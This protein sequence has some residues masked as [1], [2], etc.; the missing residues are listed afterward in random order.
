LASEQQNVLTATNDTSRNSAA[1]SMAFYESVKSQCQT[2]QGDASRLR[3]ELLH[4]AAEGGITGAA[5]QYFLATESTRER[6][7]VRD[8][9]LHKIAEDAAAGDA[10]SMSLA[11]YERSVSGLTERDRIVY[12]NALAKLATNDE[13]FGAASHAFALVLSIGKQTNS[14]PSGVSA[15]KM[16]LTPNEM[17][18][19]LA[20]PWSIANPEEARK[21]DKLTGAAIAQL[22]GS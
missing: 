15:E 13:Y 4:T 18:S 12:L 19:V 17:K 6:E 11:T 8:D 3:R 16:F 9:I 20:G 5:A 10:W 22:K 21:V 7:R 2:L 1:R 14:L